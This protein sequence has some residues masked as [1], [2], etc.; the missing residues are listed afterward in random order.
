[1]TEAIDVALLILRITVGLVFIAHG[2]KHA[3]G[4]VKTSNWFGSLGFRSPQFQWFMS[5]TT[6]IG[7]GVLLVLGLFTSVAAAGLIGIMF[8]AFWTVHRFAGFFITAFMKED[9]DVEGWEYVFV[10]ALVGFVL[11][12]GGPGT[13][14][15]DDAIGIA[16]DLD[17]WVG[18]A[19]AVA[20]L[21]LAFG[22]VATFW[23]PEEIEKVS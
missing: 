7:V 12:I 6:E 2:V 4:R 1:M 15:L 8:V 23:R 13:I 20:G 19:I 14:S 5:T 21:V 9:V 22:Q 10:L 16:D 18:F 17:G 11:A 3:R